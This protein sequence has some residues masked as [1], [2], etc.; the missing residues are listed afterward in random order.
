MICNL[1][2]KHLTQ[3]EQMRAKRN[4]LLAD[5]DWAMAADAPTDKTKWAEYRQA[6]RDF[7]STWKPA[8]TANFP[9]APK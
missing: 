7:P 5:S 3:E 4:A 1:T 6:L 2:M 8:E 9:E